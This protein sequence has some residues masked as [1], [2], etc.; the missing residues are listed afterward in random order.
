VSATQASAAWRRIQICR[1]V[2]EASFRLFIFICLFNY[3]YFIYLFYLLICF[4]FLVFYNFCICI[5]FYYLFLFILFYF[6]IYLLLIY[7]SFIYSLFIVYLFLF[8]HLIFIVFVF[9]IYLFPFILR[10]YSIELSYFIFYLFM[11]YSLFNLRSLFWKNKFGLWDHVA[12]P[13]FACVCV[14]LCISPYFLLNLVRISRHLSQSQRPNQKIPPISPCVCMP[15]PC[16]ATAR[17]SEF[18][19]RC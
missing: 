9:I 16:Y 15:I 1:H 10:I 13:I 12:V 19:Y 3:L 4:T 14:C 6:S 8:I 5:Y 18:P 2:G 7:L 17:F 11:F